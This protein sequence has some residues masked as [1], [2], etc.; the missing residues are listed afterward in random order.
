MKKKDKKK[1]PQQVK[2]EEIHQKH[3]YLKQIKAMMGILGSESAY[4]LLSPKGV[5]LLFFFTS[6]PGKNNKSKRSVLKSPKV[7]FR[8]PEQYFKSMA[9]GIICQPWPREKTGKPF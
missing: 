9:S 8:H 5:E 4:E 2:Q 6:S 7:Q 3:C 1:N